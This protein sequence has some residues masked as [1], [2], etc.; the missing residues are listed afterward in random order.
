MSNLLITGGAGYVGAVLVPKLI[1]AGHQVA[2]LDL[3]VFGT[4]VFGAAQHSPQLELIQGDI[5]NLDLVRQALSGRDTVI[6]LACISNDPSFEL[7]PAL[8]TSINLAAFAPLVDA[9]L[10]AGCQRFIYAS[11]SS[12]Y[13][14]KDEPDVS[15][16]LSLEPLTDYSRFKAQCETILLERCADQ[17]MV[18]LII[19][20]ATVCGYSP[21]QRLDL[22]V[23]ILTHHAVKNGKIRVFGGNQKRPNLHI[24]DMTDLYLQALSWPDEKIRGRIYNVGYE[25]H[26][27]L[28]IAHMVRAE[29]G[30]HVEIVVEPTDDHRSYHISSRKIRD[31]LG[32]V[33]RHTIQD[34]IRE[35]VAAFAQGLLPDSMEADQYYNIRVMQKF[36]AL[37]NPH[38]S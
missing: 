8:G 5:R 7:D 29:V 1:A 18:P 23:N 9:A 4:E 25:N 30:P 2:V 26:T 33:P 37:P 36:Q 6:H 10:A 17:A 21:R 19:R 38:L 32:F 31:E 28:E 22:T 35:L 12:V 20:P 14:V 11:S 3:C 13:G 15:E 16:E 27:V 24:Q 34:A